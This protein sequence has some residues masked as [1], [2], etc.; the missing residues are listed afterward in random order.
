MELK[1]PHYAILALALHGISQRQLNSILWYYGI[2]K[3]Q[4]MITNQLCKAG[5]LVKDH[6][7]TMTI[8]ESGQIIVMERA[9]NDF[10]I[11]QLIILANLAAASDCSIYTILNNAEQILESGLL[12]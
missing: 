9:K 4:A 12:C 11:R 8:T 6:A 1:Y 3:R 5:L 2:T 7:G 10:G